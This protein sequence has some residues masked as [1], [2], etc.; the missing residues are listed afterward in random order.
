VEFGP[1]CNRARYRAQ[2]S[3]AC[4]TSF[5]KDDEMTSPNPSLTDEELSRIARA[6]LMAS[7]QLKLA[8]KIV[9]DAGFSNATSVPMFVAAVLQ[10]M[11]TNQQQLTGDR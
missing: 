9:T 2:Q 6:G 7:E 10:A 8:K 11:A 5:L 3:C 4:A 1:A